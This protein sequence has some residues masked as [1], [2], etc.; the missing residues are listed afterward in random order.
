MEAERKALPD[1][2]DEATSRHM[3]TATLFDQ[4]VLLIGQAFNVITC[5]I[6]STRQ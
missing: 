2:D 1:N 3:G 6:F 4:N 5:H